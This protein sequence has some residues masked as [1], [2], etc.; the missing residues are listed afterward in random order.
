MDPTSARFYKDAFIVEGNE[1]DNLML[2][3]INSS[4]PMNIASIA[5]DAEKKRIYFLIK[6][7]TG[8]D[9]CR[10]GQQTGRE[11]TPELGT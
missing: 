5:D 6:D 10:D 8:V 7:I 4:L 11:H 3:H 2:Q 1:A 9:L